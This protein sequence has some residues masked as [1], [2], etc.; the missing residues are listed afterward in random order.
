MV[1]GKHRSACGVDTN[2][3]SVERRFLRIFEAYWDIESPVPPLSPRSYTTTFTCSSIILVCC[4]ALCSAGNRWRDVHC[5]TSGGNFPYDAILYCTQDSMWGPSC[6]CKI[7]CTWINRINTSSAEEW[8][9]FRFP[10]PVRVSRKV[11]GE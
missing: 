3:R 4:L 10:T 1:R 11:C 8:R 6:H 2:P 9:T 7:E 5:G